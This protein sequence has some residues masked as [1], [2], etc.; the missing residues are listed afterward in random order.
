[1]FNRISGHP[2]PQSS[3][4]IK[5]TIT[6]DFLPLWEDSYEVYSLFLRSL[7]IFI[8]SSSVSLKSTLLVSFPYLSHFPAPQLNFIRSPKLH[9]ESTYVIYL[10]NSIAVCMCVFAILTQGFLFF[11]FM[12]ENYLRGN[13][14]GDSKSKCSFTKIFWGETLR[15]QWGEEIH[16]SNINRVSMQIQLGNASIVSHPSVAEKCPSAYFLERGHLL[17][18]RQAKLHLKCKAISSF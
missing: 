11:V 1:M 9:T 7:A 2:L 16:L 4:H 10:M 14:S 13:T 6:L 5:L 12:W 15:V 18:F 8:S 3:W 17:S